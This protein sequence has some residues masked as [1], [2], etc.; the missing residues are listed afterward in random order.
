MLARL[1]RWITAKVK[2]SGSLTGYAKG[3]LNTFSCPEVSVWVLDS[4]HP[5]LQSGIQAGIG[6]GV[7]DTGTAHHMGQIRGLVS[8][9]DDGVYITRVPGTSV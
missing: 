1:S 4:I 2:V 7:V 5:P 6:A 8:A 3:K 9:T